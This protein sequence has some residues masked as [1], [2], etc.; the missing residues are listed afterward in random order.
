MRLP[1]LAALALATTGLVAACG[2]GDGGGGGD[3]AAGTGATPAEFSAPVVGGEGELA[4]ASL[5]GRDTVLW[6]WAPWC[7]TCRAEADDVVDAAA[8]LDGEVEIIGVAGRGEVPEMEGF[9]AD[10]GTGGLT[11]VA[12]TDGAIWSSYGVVT[13]PAFAFLDDSGEVE[14]VVGSLGRDALVERMDALAA[15]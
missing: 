9:V 2:G 10:T 7:T 13:Q 15:A 1:R 12:D 6:F 8:A 5:E 11:H 14:V 4:S 3:G